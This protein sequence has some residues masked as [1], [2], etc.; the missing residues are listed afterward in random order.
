LGVQDGLGVAG[1]VQDGQA[2]ADGVDAGGDLV[3]EH[4]GHYHVGEQEVDGLG[5]VAGVAQR[6]GWGGGGADVVAVAGQDAAG[7]F[8]QACSSSTSRTVSPRPPA[9]A[10]VVVVVALAAGVAPAWVAGSSAVTAVP[11]PGSE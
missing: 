2:G 11:A 8:P 1:H 5:Q 10:V 3:A 9:A 7:Q 6:A 4:V